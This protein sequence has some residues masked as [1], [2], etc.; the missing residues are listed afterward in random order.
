MKLLLARMGQARAAVAV[1]TGS[2]CCRA[3]RL[4]GPPRMVVNSGSSGVPASSEKFADQVRTGEIGWYEVPEYRRGSSRRP[5]DER[6]VVRLPCWP[7][8]T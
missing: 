2:R 4:I 3:S 7:G 6:A 5:S 8:L 1:W